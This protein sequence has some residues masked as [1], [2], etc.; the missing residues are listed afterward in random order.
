MDP[1]LTT[2]LAGLVISLLVLDHRVLSRRPVPPTR[3][4]IL[5]SVGLWSIAAV[6]FGT[7]LF[8]GYQAQFNG[9]GSPTVQG[10]LGA[11]AQFVTALIV[12]LTLSLDNLAVLVLIFAYFKVPREAQPRAIFWCVLVSLVIRLGL[13]SGTGVLLQRYDWFVFFLG[14]LILLAMWRLLV[15]PGEGTN[16]NRRPLIRLVRRVIPAPG[17]FDGNAL[18]TRSGDGMSRSRWTLTPLAPAV[19]VGATADVT[20]ALDSIPAVFAVTDDT[21]IAFASHAFALLLL[22]PLY[23]GVQGTLRRFRYLKVTIFMVLLFLGM[24][25]VLAR[26]GG[27]AIDVLPDE[28]DDVELVNFTLITTE[29]LL[30]VVLL[31]VSLGVS[32]S[33]LH[34]WMDRRATGALSRSATASEPRPS[35][36][37]DLARAVEI[38]QS[39]LWRLTILFTGLIVAVGGSIIIG[40]LPGPGGVFVFLAGLGILATEFAW[41]RRLLS[42]VQ[43]RAQQVTEQTDRMARK[44]PAWVVYAVIALYFGVVALVALSGWVN[45]TLVLL[46]GFGGLFPLGFWVWRSLRST[47]GPAQREA[48]PL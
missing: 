25:L 44:T 6:L 19:I 21:F 22:R 48:G 13:I 29:I 2:I 32:G 31:I 20:Y 43:R 47:P 39:N 41:A 26:P 37:E 33:A 15:M 3:A 7:A 30:V 16:L 14:M 24:R 8:L 10:G 17:P 46:V 4:G 40:P 36:A 27:G 34:A 1:T 35:V 9:T 28:W 11:V 38:A 12:E 42:E 5:L 45:P 18:M 23:F